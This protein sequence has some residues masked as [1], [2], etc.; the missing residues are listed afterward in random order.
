MYLKKQRKLLARRKYRAYIYKT[1]PDK[2]RYDTTYRSEYD[3][4]DVTS[5]REVEFVEA[6]WHLFEEACIIIVRRGKIRPLPK[7]SRQ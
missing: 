7:A 5:R 3:V 2:K 1:K 4:N 6:V